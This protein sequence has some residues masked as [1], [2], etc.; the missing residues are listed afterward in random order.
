MYSEKTSDYTAVQFDKNV[1]RER[2]FRTW[3][4]VRGDEAERNLIFLGVFDDSFWIPSS[5]RRPAFRMRE[6][7]R[8]LGPFDTRKFMS[9]AGYCLLKMNDELM[10]LLSSSCT[11]CP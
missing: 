4:I 3:K 8:F 1:A 2:H 7:R 10:M 11:E 5:R 9:N 6:G